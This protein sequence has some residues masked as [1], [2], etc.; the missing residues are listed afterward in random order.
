[1]TSDSTEARH[2]A[3]V[4]RVT[5]EEREYLEELERVPVVEIPL[6][7]DNSRIWKNYKGKPDWCRAVT[8]FV[9]LFI[10]DIVLEI[11]AIF[12]RRGRAPLPA[13][14]PMPTKYKGPLTVCA[15]VCMLCLSI[16]TKF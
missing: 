12:S 2:R 7:Q 13:F 8:G 6:E 5:E 9:P 15:T 11:A 10:H 4:A 1:M 3:L 14:S 16:V